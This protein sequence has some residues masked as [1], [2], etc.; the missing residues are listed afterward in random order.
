MH[1]FDTGELAEAFAYSLAKSGKV[2][3][4]HHGKP[5]TV[6]QGKA[7]VKFVNAIEAMSVSDSQRYMASATGQYKFGN[8]RLGKLAAKRR[9]GE[10]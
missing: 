8:E 3:I 7:A 5:V 9:S 10:S 4:S 2:M 6:L 1:D